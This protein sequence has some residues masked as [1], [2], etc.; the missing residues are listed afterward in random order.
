M[1]RRRI[2]RGRSCIRRCSRTLLLI[3]LRTRG[4]G[5]LRGKREVEREEAVVDCRRERRYD[6][7]SIYCISWLVAREWRKAIPINVP[8]Y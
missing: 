1:R 3:G 5:E 7:W 6:A 4:S 8:P 2:R